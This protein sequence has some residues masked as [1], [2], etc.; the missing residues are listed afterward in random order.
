MESFFG[1]LKEELVHRHASATHQEARRALTRYV[2]VFY[3]H[4]RRHSALRYQT[5]AAH[6][7]AYHHAAARAA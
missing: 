6:E 7:A 2:E 4:Q 1:T 5:P 3:N